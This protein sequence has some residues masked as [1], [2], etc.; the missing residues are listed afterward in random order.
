[1]VRAT[2]TTHRKWATG[3]LLL[4]LIAMLPSFMQVLT[5][6]C[7]RVPEID[8]EDCQVI[9]INDAV[10]REIYGR[11]VR[12]FATRA[13]EGSSQSRE[14][15]TIDSG[16]QVCIRQQDPGLARVS[17]S[18][19]VEIGLTRIRKTGAVVATVHHSVRVAVVSLIDGS[20]AV[21]VFPIA[22]LWRAGIPRRIGVV[23]VSATEDGRMIPLCVIPR[24]ALNVS[25]AVVVGLGRG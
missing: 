22:G 13:A 14:I 17:D 16:R 25:V 19:A 6:R 24:S 21:I 9:A 8:R 18:V 1:M 20:V 12:G 11:L 4:N 7:S 2:N 23:A 3:N 5:G 15:E 10:A